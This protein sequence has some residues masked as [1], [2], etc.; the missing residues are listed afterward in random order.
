MRINVLDSNNHRFA[1]KGACPHCRENS[2]F[3]LVTNTHQEGD[4]KGSTFYCGAMQCQGCDDFI[5]G[6]VRRTHKDWEYLA[7]YP[8]G[9]PDDAVDKNVPEAIAN[10]F[11][12]AMRCLW[13]NS[14]KATVVMCRRSVEATCKHL[15]ATGR[16]L[17]KKIDNLAA[18]GKITEPLRQ[19]AH[20]VRLSGNRGAHGKKQA[21]RLD[22]NPTLALQSGEPADDLDMFGEDEAKAMIDFVEQLFQHVYVM[23]ARLEKYKPKPK[24]EASEST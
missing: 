14:Y 21:E 24:G 8:I 2:V 11:A 12:E 9:F 23:P 22:S 10:D 16:D 13:A 7:H 6:I 20:V 1:L 19:M 3:V 18:Q 15:G 5:L 4:G 17:E